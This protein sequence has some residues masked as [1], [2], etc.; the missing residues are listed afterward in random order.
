MPLPL[1]SPVYEQIIC[2]WS[3]QHPRHDHQ[4]IFPLKN[5][6]LI[7]VW[8]EY[9][10]NS[11]STITRDQYEKSGSTHDG[12]PCRIS[13]KISTDL[14]RTWSDTFTLQD[15][16][17]DQNVKHPNLIR[18]INGDIL[19]TF[20]AWENDQQ[21]NVFMITSYASTSTTFAKTSNLSSSTPTMNSKPGRDPKVL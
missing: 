15:N 6:R 1:I 11:P 10:A 19:F 9:Y 20:T 2:P 13:A 5:D 17:W 7:L 4:L 8:S 18:L 14:G 3:P 12:F 21:R 16:L